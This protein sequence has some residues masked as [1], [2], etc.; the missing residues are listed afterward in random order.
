M[1]GVTGFEPM[2]SRPPGV[3]ATR[4][5]Q[6]P[7]IHESPKVLYVTLDI[8]RFNARWVLSKYLHRNILFELPI[9]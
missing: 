9:I 4:L 5:R 7:R 3:R 1:V 8:P 6:T 2:P